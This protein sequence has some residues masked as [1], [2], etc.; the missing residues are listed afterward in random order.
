MMWN[1]TDAAVITLAAMPFATAAIGWHYGA[2]WG[3]HEGKCDERER[4]IERNRVH[5]DNR[6]LAIKAGR[7]VVAPGPR[8]G[9]GPAAPASP[10]GQRHAERSRLV[11]AP[12]ATAASIAPVFI[13]RP[14]TQIPMRPQPRKVSDD[15]F[16]RGL[17]AITD[18]VV[19]R[20]ERGEPVR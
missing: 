6:Y 12:P 7:A 3:R 5:L 9:I 13:P 14:G 4:Q 2:A 10:Q 8:A 19:A 20:I 18:D 15:S 16:I 1:W 11:T 17:A